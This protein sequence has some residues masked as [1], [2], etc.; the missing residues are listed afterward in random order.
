MF[1]VVKALALTVALTVAVFGPAFREPPKDSFPFSTYPMFS[2]GKPDPD[3]VLTQV[4]AVF[5]DGTSKP[6]PPKLTTG[7]EEV[8]QAMGTILREAYGSREGSRAFCERIAARVKASGDEK[9]ADVIRIEIVRSQFDV[10]RYFDEGP[11]P[12]RKKPVRGCLVKR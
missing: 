10:L 11:E 8:I 7:N 4:R 12:I 3:L 1:E 6:L 5:A 9:W 2:A